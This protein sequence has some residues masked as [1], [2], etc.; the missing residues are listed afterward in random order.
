MS[1]L[2]QDR[3]I[4]RLSHKLRRHFSLLENR[5]E[6][7]SI[8]NRQLSILQQNILNIQNISEELLVTLEKMQK[9]LK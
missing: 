9:D 2:I 3:E 5:V 7:Y 6:A 1:I 4:K 8:E